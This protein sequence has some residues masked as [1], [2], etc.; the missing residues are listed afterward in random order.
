MKKSFQSPNI[1]LLALLALGSNCA[2]RSHRTSLGKDSS[3]FQQ[4]EKDFY[5]LAANELG[6]NEAASKPEL[7]IE[8][9]FESKTE[10]KIRYILK[11]NETF[12]DGEYIERKTTGTAVLKKNLA[13]SDGEWVL[14]SVEDANQKMIFKKGSSI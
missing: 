3:R 7:K 2:H 5:A 1:A 14:D 12:A 13:S 11:Y 10:V 4:F 8:T 6:A 9:I